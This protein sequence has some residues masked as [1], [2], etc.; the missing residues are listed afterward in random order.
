MVWVVNVIIFCCRHKAQ[1]GASPF[2]DHQK[3]P[4][5]TNGNS[6]SS[7]PDGYH[8]SRMNNRSANREQLN[9]HGN[10]HTDEK[11]RGEVSGPRSGSRGEQLNAHAD[12]KQQGEVS[13]HRSSRSGNREQL[14]GHGDEKQGGESSGASSSRAEKNL[15]APAK[16]SPNETSEEDLQIQREAEEYVFHKFGVCDSKEKRIVFKLA[17]EEQY[18]K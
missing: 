8:N 5:L 18:P 10:A 6:N 7:L 13:G 16:T 15:A 1:N 2:A 3:R 4:D 12:E 11:Q 14:N 17:Y 9:G